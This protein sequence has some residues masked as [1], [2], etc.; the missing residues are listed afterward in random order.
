MG[1]SN[2]SLNS[3]ISVTSVLAETTGQLKREE[4]ITPEQAQAYKS[5]SEANDNSFKVRQV[6]GTWK[7]NEENERKMR[8][9]VAAFVLGALGVEMLIGN[10]IFVLMG[11]NPNFKL[12]QWTCNLFFTGMYTQIVA[13]ATIVV[14]NLFPPT[15]KDSS[16]AISELIKNL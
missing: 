10:I 6:I 3:S 5:V 12:S 16:S 14:R 1:E 4:G 15:T 2:T 7:T 13:V 8:K 11:F 9:R